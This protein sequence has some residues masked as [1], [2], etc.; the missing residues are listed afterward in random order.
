MQQSRF[1]LGLSSEHPDSALGQV[2]LWDG[3]TVGAG[4]Q[5]A[6][7]RHLPRLRRHLEGSSW[8]RGLQDNFQ[9]AHEELRRQL[10]EALE[11]LQ[12]HLQNAPE[13][14]A[15]WIDEFTN[16]LDPQAMKLCRL[17]AHHGIPITAVPDIGTLH[18]AG[19][20][21][22]E[23]AINDVRKAQRQRDAAGRQTPE[24]R[25][26]EDLVPYA[27]CQLFTNLGDWLSK[28]SPEER[29][30]VADQIVKALD[31][32]GPDVQE[33]MRRVAGLN[34]LSI[35]TLVRA[36]A[37]AALGTGLA[38]ATGVGGF[39]VYAMLSA[40][41]ANVV[42]LVGLTLP[43]SAYLIVTSLLAFAANPLVVLAVVV[44][45]GARLATVA[46]QRMH[47]GLVP[48]L[49]AFAALKSDDPAARGRVQGLAEHL[50]DRY[51]E[52]LYGDRERQSQLRRA[53]PAF[54]HPGESNRA[55]WP[56]THLQHPASPWSFTP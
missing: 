22:E 42:G 31:E 16:P 27:S 53:F 23:R 29:E 45:G 34:D 26:I 2:L 38:T 30:R 4:L 55:S 14:E 19:W 11:K 8:P 35:D 7:L 47:A 12:G 28:A 6:L 13:K 56:S 17:L 33:E 52:F 46:N 36:G 1:I 44:C 9:K 24:V 18:V 37:I 48:L 40:T 20:K 15:A 10:Q 50:A 39:A 49:V 5:R 21:I 32:L 43:F 25:K 3:M 41:I 54:R 51:R